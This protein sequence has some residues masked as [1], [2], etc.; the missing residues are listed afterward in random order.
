MGDNTELKDIR[1]LLFLVLL[2]T[3]ELRQDILS[4]D[5]YSKS[6]KAV[7]RQEIKNQI[8]SICSRW[9]DVITK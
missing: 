7:M 8:E 5:L 3:Q 4:L 9:K 1:K 2:E 6:K